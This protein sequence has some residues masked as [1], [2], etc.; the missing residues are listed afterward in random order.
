MPMKR[1]ELTENSERADTHLEMKLIGKQADTI[2]ITELALN[3]PARTDNNVIIVSR[4]DSIYHN[5]LAA[6]SST[7][8]RCHDVGTIKQVNLFFICKLLNL[9][10]IIIF[11]D[12]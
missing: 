2:E 12:H 1:V 5:P 7:I 8:L 11:L 6:T 4:N 3:S 10:K 9:I